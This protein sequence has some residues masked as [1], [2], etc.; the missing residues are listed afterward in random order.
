MGRAA[1]GDGKRR[2]H[3]KEQRAPDHSVQQHGVS[4]GDSLTHFDSRNLRACE[5]IQK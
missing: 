3:R 4:H 2:N 1:G 5:T